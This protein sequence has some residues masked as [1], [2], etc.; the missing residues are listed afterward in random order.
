MYVDIVGRMEKQFVLVLEVGHFLFIEVILGEICVSFGQ[1]PWLILDVMK[2]FV[3]VTGRQNI[4]L[5]SKL[6]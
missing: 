6:F 4:K 3:M 2:C 1:Q 5:G